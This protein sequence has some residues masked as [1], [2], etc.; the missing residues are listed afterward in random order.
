MELESSNSYK[1]V[2]Y[3]AVV[4]IIFLRSLLGVQTTLFP[5]DE[6]CEEILL[7]SV[8]AIGG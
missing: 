4:V 5:T 3:I 2:V 6:F 7:H 8:V 1:Q